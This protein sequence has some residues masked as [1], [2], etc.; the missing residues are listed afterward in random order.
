MKYT[1][2]GLIKSIQTEPISYNWIFT[3][4]ENVRL[5]PTTNIFKFEI[6]TNEN[7]KITMA[8]QELGWWFVSMFQ[9]KYF[10]LVENNTVEFFN[11]VKPININESDI[12][13][14]EKFDTE[15]MLKTIY[16][17]VGKLLDEKSKLLSVEIF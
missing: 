4:E 15:Y 11:K 6:L 17:I 9:Q 13:F 10:S 3:E 14:V 8:N 12:I 7:H 1:E 16:A 5:I 2:L